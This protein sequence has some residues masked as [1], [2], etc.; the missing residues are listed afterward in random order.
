LLDVP[1][2]PD[3]VAP[4]VLSE[5]GAVR[6]SAAA[7]QRA[8]APG[9]TAARAWNALATRLTQ[10]IRAVEAERTLVMQSVGAR[11]E[12]FAGLRPTR[13]TNTWYGFHGFAPEG[14]TRRGEGVYPGQVD[15]ERWDRE[16]LQRW[17]APALEFRATYRAPLYLG[18]F[19]ATTAGQR[20][21]RLTW[22]RSLLAVCRPQV[23]GWAFHTYCDPAFGLYGGDGVDYDLLGL[24]QTE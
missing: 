16:R 10:V 6:L 23:A 19:G 4:D 5:L 13:D 18:A 12:A 17:L 8:Q 2:L 11:A 14:L 1:E 7:A 21:S 3:E 22:M 9:A 20:Q 24:L 15:G